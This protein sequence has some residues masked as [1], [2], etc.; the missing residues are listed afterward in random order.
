MVINLSIKEVIS[1]KLQ[2][3]LSQTLQQPFVTTVTWVPDATY[4]VTEEGNTLR[5][6][7]KVT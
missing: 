3:D 6:K 2:S 5:H 4:V 1:V 7:Y